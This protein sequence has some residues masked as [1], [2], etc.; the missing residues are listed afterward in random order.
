MVAGMRTAGPTVAVADGEGDADTEVDGIAETDALAAG[1]GVVEGWSDELELQP[2][3]RT[4]SVT[5]GTRAEAR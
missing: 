1:D 5:A 2:A 3:S 4:A